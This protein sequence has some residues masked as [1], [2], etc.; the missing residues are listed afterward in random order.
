MCD[1]VLKKAVSAGL[2]SASLPHFGGFLASPMAAA[3]PCLGHLVCQHKSMLL[4]VDP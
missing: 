3:M 1:A 2:S 4:L